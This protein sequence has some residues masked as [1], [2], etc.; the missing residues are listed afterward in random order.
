MATKTK[1]KAKRVVQPIRESYWAVRIYPYRLPYLV[2]Q[3]RPNVPRLFD[4]REDAVA[5]IDSETWP[6]GAR[7]KAIRVTISHPAPSR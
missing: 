3:P 4:S 7:P 2:W 5:F 1:T 6:E